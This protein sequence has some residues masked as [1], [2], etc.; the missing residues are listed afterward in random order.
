MKSRLVNGT[1]PDLLNV[2]TAEP[3]DTF[4]TPA[5]R[6]HAIGKGI[7]LVEIQQTSDLTYRISDWNRK[8]TGKVKRELH[9]ELALEAM[10]FN[11]AGKNKIRKEPELNKTEN[12]VNC[13]FFNTNILHFN[14]AIKKEYHLIDSFV[15]YICVDGEFQIRWDGNSEKVTKG[16]TVLL[17]AMIKEVILEP[18]VDARVLEV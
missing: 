12:L 13:E 4:F 16:E 8:S 3:G 7:V 2:E 15:V 9:L 5:G 11:A 14:T 17:P 1:L 18:S 10:D 6:I